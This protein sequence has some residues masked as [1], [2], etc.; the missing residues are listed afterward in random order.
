MRGRKTRNYSFVVP[1]GNQYQLIGRILG[2][3]YPDKGGDGAHV[4]S[5]LPRPILPPAGERTSWFLE[6]V[7]SLETRHEA[8]LSRLQGT[9]GPVANPHF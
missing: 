2:L 6:H 3:V 1:R 4:T 8:I 5:E 9:T 7:L